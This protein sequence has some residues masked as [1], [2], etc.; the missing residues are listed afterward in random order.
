M[1]HTLLCLPNELT[2]CRLT[3]SLFVKIITIIVFAIANKSSNG[4]M[5]A[6]ALDTAKKKKRNGHCLHN[7]VR[8]VDK[9]WD[10][11]NLRLG[12]VTQSSGKEFQTIMARSVK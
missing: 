7:T 12:E 2:S 10:L 1:A 4:T 6:L 3:G 5:Y 8:S 11:D 9:G